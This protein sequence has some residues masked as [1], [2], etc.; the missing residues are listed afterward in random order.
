MDG[1]RRAELMRIFQAGLDAVAPDKA[2][3]RHLRMQN[4]WLRA[5]DG[6]YDLSAG[7][8]L[9]L[10][11]GKGAAPMAAALES[12]LGDRI[13]DG[14]VVVKYDHDLPLRRIRLAQAA[15]PVPDQ[16]GVDASA[17]ML[18]MA[19][20]AGPDDLVICVFTG[21]ASA[22]TPAPAPGLCLADLQNV[23]RT[24]L[25]CGA[26]INQL[27]AVRKHL[28]LFGGG[29]LARAA[30]PARVLTILVS[31]V[32]GDRLD[33]IASGPTAPDPSTYAECLEIVTA[34]G[35]ADR[36][37]PAAMQ[38]LRAG[39]SGDVPETP[40]P[41]DAVF[42]S[43][44]HVLVATNRQA[45]DAAAA[46]AVTMGWQSRIL[47][48]TLQGEAADVVVQ[49]AA[50]ARQAA[51]TRTEGC[52]LCLLSGGE[53]TVTVRGKGCGGRNQEMALA[54]N[55]V[56]AGEE[57]ITALFGGTDGS[58]GPTDAA[59]GFACGDG[60]HAMRQAGVD[61][62]AELAD[63]NSHAAL[64]RA[65]LLLRTGPTRTNVMDIAIF[66]VE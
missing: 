36:L 57:R 21:G 4:G 3:L 66:L 13:D 47:T 46:E 7:K 49:L 24:L 58:D 16:A 17:D 27:N 5:G 23:T 35:V 65:N 20:S 26:T 30:S 14:L 33:V 11:G 12:L 22:L 34:F 51:A 42:D 62:V 43:V 6:R 56:L 52:P 29:E 15:H 64:E 37:P 50:D 9:V 60:E 32:V 8:V 39:A 31:D 53:T 44:R 63:N 48:D 59:G 61:P 38:R 45:L 54:A 55:L 28:G 18:R 10:G 41:G 25:E 19:K 1:A 40:K 2:L